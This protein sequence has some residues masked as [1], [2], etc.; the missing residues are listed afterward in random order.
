MSGQRANNTDLISEESLYSSFHPIARS[1]LKYWNSQ[2][3]EVHQDEQTAATVQ[4]LNEYLKTGNAVI[5]FD[6]HYT[7]DAIPVGLTLGKLLKSAKHALVPYAVHLE[8]GVNGNGDPTLRYHYRTKL[9]KWLVGKVQESNPTIHIKPVARS[10]EMKNDKMRAIVNSK[11]EG[12]SL[13][14]LQT[15]YQLFQECSSGLVCILSPIGGL[16][17]PERPTLYDRLYGLM[18]GAQQSLGKPFQFFYVSAYPQ[19]K[20]NFNYFAPILTKH[21]FVARGPF[22]LPSDDYDKANEFMTKEVNKLRSVANFELPDYDKI[23]NK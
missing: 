1:V 14:Y 13:D 7:F 3:S 8:M 23:K 9:F 6:H 12:V 22:E 2:I 10:F 4:H 16:A 5:F 11:F 18:D 20:S 21:V 19:L 15:F 17:L